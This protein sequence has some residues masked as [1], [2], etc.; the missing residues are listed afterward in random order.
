MC[1]VPWPPSE[2]PFHLEARA[3][4]G[5]AIPEHTDSC[6]LAQAPDGPAARAVKV[7]PAQRAGCPG[8]GEWTSLPGPSRWTLRVASY[9]PEGSCELPCYWVELQGD[10][11]CEP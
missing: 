8:P 5:G 7:L 3:E 4:S 10:G 9:R 11:G 1:P 6:F 2:F